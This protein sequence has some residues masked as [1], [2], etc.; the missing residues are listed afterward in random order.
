MGYK[1]DVNISLIAEIFEILF[2]KLPELKIY[3]FKTSLKFL[4]LDQPT[5]N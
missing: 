2:Q 5:L 1:K 3:I 4:K